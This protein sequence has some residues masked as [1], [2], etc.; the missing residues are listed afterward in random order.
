M[1][2]LRA[3]WKPAALAGA[4]ARIVATA[5]SLPEV[6][7]ARKVLGFWSMPDRL[8]VDVRPLLRTLSESGTTVGLPVVSRD[9]A[10]RFLRFRRFE[11]EHRLCDGPFG[12]VHPDEASDA[13]EPGEGDVVL[14]PALA[15]DRQGI[16]LG[17]GAGY[18]DRWLAAHPVVAVCPIFDACL[19]DSLPTETHDR[20]VSLIVTERRVLRI[21]NAA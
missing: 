18:Y 11:G 17:W 19:V 16:R 3:G 21:G 1:V 6:R 14:V 12:T 15:V 20:A 4:S 2:S 7:A 8:E 13:V 5:A 10:D 9:R